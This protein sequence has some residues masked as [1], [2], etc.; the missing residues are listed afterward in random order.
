MRRPLPTLPPCPPKRPLGARP[1][2]PRDRAAGLAGLFKAL[3]SGTRLRLLHALARAGEIRPTDL[4]REVGMRPQAVSNQ[5]QRLVDR[6]FLGARRDGNSTLYRIEDPCVTDLLDRG[7]C[8]L[9]D[10][11]GR[12]RR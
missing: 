4:A 7:L 11:R 3:A 12:R 2:L 9:E 6:G 8:L 10:A 5:L 1:L